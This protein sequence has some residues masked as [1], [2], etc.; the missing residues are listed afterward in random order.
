MISVKELFN[1][2]HKVAIDKLLHFIVGLMIAQLGA[3][4]FGLFLGAYM[5]IFFGWILSVLVTMS[6][7]IWDKR[8]DG[9]CSYADFSAGFLGAII[10]SLI[11]LI[12]L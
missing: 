5:K 8:H 12:T 1:W 7:E 10:G 11:L 6:K 4:L 3:A 2:L 9:V